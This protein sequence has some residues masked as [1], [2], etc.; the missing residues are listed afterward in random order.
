MGDL[1]N[2]RTQYM[3]KITDTVNEEHEVLSRETQY[4]TS[5]RVEDNFS[6]IYSNDVE[7][8]LGMPTR[9]MN[10]LILL[11]KM[12]DY[13]NRGGYI[14]LPSGAKKEICKKLNIKCMSSLDNVISELIKGKVIVRES[15]GVYRLNPFIFGKGTWNDVVDMR[16]Q[17][18][19]LYA[20]THNKRFIDYVPPR[21]GG[22]NNA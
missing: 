22:K 13:A 9:C 3:A 1:P 7:F 2:Y 8:L 21:K 20:E 5:Y 10:V 18:P 15:L 12:S 19:E 16:E 6:K 14:L 17:Y 4:K 11:I